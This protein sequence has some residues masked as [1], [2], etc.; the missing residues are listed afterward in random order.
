MK[1]NNLIPFYAL[2][3]IVAITFSNCRKKKETVI[4][5]KPIKTYIVKFKFDYTNPSATNVH[6][7]VTMFNGALN[8]TYSNVSTGF[9]FLISGKTGDEISF[10]ANNYASPGYC[11]ATTSIYLDGTLWQADPANNSSGLA[12]SY[13]NGVIP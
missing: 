6:N 4:P 10:Y 9:E 11:T 3:L 13:C 1:K 5:E 12:D 2:L 8:Y 7:S